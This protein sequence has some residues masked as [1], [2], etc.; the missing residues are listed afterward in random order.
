MLG[1]HSITSS[2]RASNAGGIVNPSALGEMDVSDFMAFESVADE[3][4][5][6]GTKVVLRGGFVIR[7]DLTDDQVSLEG[8]RG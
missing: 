2:A 8:L 4:G 6:I 7:R 1:V 3:R 5:A